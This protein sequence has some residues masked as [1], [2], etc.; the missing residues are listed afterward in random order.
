MP[1]VTSKDR[2]KFNRP[3]KSHCI[4][5]YD[6]IQIDLTT[7]EDSIKPFYITAILI[8]IFISII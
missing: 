2:P 4:K 8:L 3:E 5:K 1:K 7:L 6:I